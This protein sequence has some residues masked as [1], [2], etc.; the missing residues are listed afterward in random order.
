MRDKN[1]SKEIVE[2]LN[3]SNREEAFFSIGSLL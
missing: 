2:I 3:L 1:Y